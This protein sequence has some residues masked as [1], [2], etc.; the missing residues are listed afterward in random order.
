VINGTTRP[1]QQ[2]R[3]PWWGGLIALALI[4]ALCAIC[5]YGLLGFLSELLPQE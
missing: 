2:N 1:Q 3:W 5:G 4:V